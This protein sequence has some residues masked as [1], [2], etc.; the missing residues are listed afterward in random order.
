[1]IVK[2][3]DRAAFAALFP[4]LPERSN[5]GDMGRL[6]VVCGSYDPYGYAMCGAAYFAAL[7]AY[8]CGAGIVEIFT[9]KE[10]YSAL[11]TLVPEAV[12]SLYSCDEAQGDVEKRLSL[13][14]ERSNAVVLGCGL[15]KSEMSVSLVKTVLEKVKRP[16]LI[17]ADGLNIISD[18]QELWAL[19][20][21]E[22]RSRTVITPHPGEMSRLCSASIDNILGDVEKY[23]RAF[24]SEKGIVCLLKDHNT[25][26]TDGR[27]V[28]INQSG[29]AGMATAGMGD[30]L[31][32]IIGALLARGEKNRLCDNSEAIL[33]RAAV[34]AYL[35]GY[36]GDLAAEKM[37]QY[38]LMASDLLLEISESIKG[39]FGQ[40]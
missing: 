7:A 37:G 30:V 33:L 24:A 23:A 28:Y 18:S 5:K 32:G 9:P 13:A 21:P 10:N 14:L 19:L 22:Q 27:I 1:M 8:R 16:L 20:S 2:N 36:A 12:F 6:L 4:S 15:G 40:I 31:S 11:A 39:N 35:H 17:D 29:N 38:S 34:G 26:I 3:I 25:V